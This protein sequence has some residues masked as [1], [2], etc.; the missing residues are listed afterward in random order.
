MTM[1][2]ASSTERTL[3][4]S[5]YTRIVIAVLVLCTVPQ[6]QSR[7]R[8]TP[9]TRA[10]VA[11]VSELEPSSAL[12]V[13]HGGSVAVAPATT[14]SPSS[15]SAINISSSN[16]A[17]KTNPVNQ[18]VGYVKKSVVGTID[19]CGELWSNHGRCNEI[20]KK[21][22]LHRDVLQQDLISAGVLDK[23][24]IKDKVKAVQGGIT[25]D[26][27]IFLQKGKEDRGKVLNMGFLMWGAPRFLP[28][29]MMFNPNMLPSPFARHEKGSTES[30]SQ[31]LS[32]ERSAA[33]L[34]TLLAME[35]SAV[36]SGML[37]KVNIFGGKKRKQ[38]QDQLLD[39]KTRAGRLMQQPQVSSAHV[40]DCLE[41][42]LYAA[43]FTRSE[44]RLCQVPAAV[45][46]GIGACVGGGGG[47]FASVLPTFLARGKILGHI[48]KVADADDFL[49]QANV[50][51]AS[52][53]YRLLKEACSERLIGGPGR[54]EEELRQHLDE[55]L[56]VVVRQPAEKVAAVQKTGAPCEFNDNLARMALMGYHSCLAVRDPRC[57]SLMPRLLL[58]SAGTTTV[59]N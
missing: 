23:Q 37:A 54:S 40:M 6:A 5:S 44:Q 56:N 20:R 34:Q 52:I 19:G 49:L 8:A 2:K 4:I 31:Q 12:S 9:T 57:A 3:R 13:N 38:E 43:N 47:I 59:A 36:T 15:A 28:Y 55:W 24:E 39:L 42:H 7:S 58:G 48:R 25:Y 27:Y 14:I 45:V 18:V 11:T 33:V 35:K 1:G 10:V 17:S 53:N 30:A 22:K 50:D 41:P 26:D 29:A 32:R 16:S 51:L 46:K 21:I